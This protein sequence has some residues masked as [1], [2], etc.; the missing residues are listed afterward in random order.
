MQTKKEYASALKK[1]QPG[2]LVIYDLS[3]PET[4]KKRDEKKFKLLK[5]KKSLKK[6]KRPKTLKPQVIKMKLKKNR[7]P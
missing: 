3:E 2:D 6:R 5:K 1:D 7:E 4:P